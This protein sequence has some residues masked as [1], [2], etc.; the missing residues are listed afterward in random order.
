MATFD[1][2][3]IPGIGINTKNKLLKLGISNSR[4]LCFHLPVSYQDKTKLQNICQLNHDDFGYIECEI[5]NKKILYKPRKI[6]Y[7]ST[8]RSTGFFTTNRRKYFCNHF[9]Q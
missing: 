5:L 2:E 3:N 6:M 9:L 7:G 1:L 4:D 8:Y